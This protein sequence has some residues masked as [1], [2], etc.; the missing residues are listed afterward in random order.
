MN[1]QG[2]AVEKPPAEGLA[3]FDRAPT[4]EQERTLRVLGVAETCVRQAAVGQDLFAY[5]EDEH[6]TL[7]L[8]IG[9]DGGVVGQTV[10]NREPHEDPRR[11]V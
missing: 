11:E 4:H 1:R 3:R 6:S 7:R 9:P 2:L 10:L 5:M 8:Q